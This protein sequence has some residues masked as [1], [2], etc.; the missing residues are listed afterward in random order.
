MTTKLWAI[1]LMV[2]CTAFTSFAQVFYKLGAAKLEFNLT[3]I[4][5]TVLY[6]F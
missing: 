1:G 6:L 3:F 2:L 5:G 4:T